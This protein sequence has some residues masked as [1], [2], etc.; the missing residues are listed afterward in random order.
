MAPAMRRIGRMS[1][2]ACLS[3]APA[4]SSADEAGDAGVSE[5]T[6]DTG[7]WFNRGAGGLR[8]DDFVA[9]AGL[10]FLAYPGDTI[11]LSA[12]SSAG[13]QGV[14]LGYQWTQVAGPP[15]TLDDATS[16]TPSFLVELPGTIAFDLEVGAA[17]VFS[18]PDRSYVVVIDRDAGRAHDAGGCGC[19]AGVPLAGWWPLA[20]VALVRR[21]R[22]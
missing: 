2:M 8:P 15:V 1:A 14:Q 11:I 21:R 10:P 20:V 13:P 18:E 17:G 12:E 6:A 22:R 5:D 4:L 7:I 9:N 3:M 19:G 16:A